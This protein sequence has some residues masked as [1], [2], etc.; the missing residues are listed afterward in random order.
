MPQVSASVSVVTPSFNT[1]RFIA[2]A[3]QSVLAQDY[4][5]L[6]YVVMDGGSTDQTLDVLKSLGE[7][8]SW[9]SEPDAGQADAI[10]RGFS[11]T[12]GEILGWLNSDDTY[13]PGAIGVAADY[14][15][16]HPDVALVY[17]NA[18]FI[19]STGAR[20]GRCAHVEPF[21]RH[22]LMHYSDFIVQP[23]AFF[24]RSAFEAVGG[25]DASLNWAMDYDLW[26]KLARRF[27]VAYLPHVLAQYRWLSDN[28]S[29]V[30]GW[31]RLQEVERVSR[32]HG[33][34]LPAYFRLEQINLLLQEAHQ[35]ARTAQP[36][37]WAEKLWRAANTL[38]RSPGAM[39][40]LLSC[41]TWRI[42][43]TGRLLRARAAPH[44]RKANSKKQK[45]KISS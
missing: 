30:G 21:S 26:I 14:F 16:A 10:N 41:Q 23:A 22:R 28:K 36:K 34:A 2:A 27:K 20:I 37:D 25:L 6:E 13:A 32:R 9:I 4:P 38:L 12:S 39:R 40:S 35:A 18:D 5:Q 43:S 7:R 15:Q 19:D 11:R 8:V 45:S 31:A 1:G 33:I 3:V 17:G 29:A 44:R 42:I 24:R